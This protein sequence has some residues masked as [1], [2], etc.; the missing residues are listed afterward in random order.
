MA[1]ILVSNGADSSSSFN[2]ENK[3]PWFYSDLLDPE[4]KEKM[5]NIMS[6]GLRSMLSNVRVSPR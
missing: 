1:E 6:E 5:A 2:I 3:L 4:S